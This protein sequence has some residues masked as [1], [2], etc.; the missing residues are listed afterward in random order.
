MDKIVPLV[1]H[2]RRAERELSAWQMQAG[3]EPVTQSRLDMHVA[4]QLLGSSYAELRY[5][6]QR[7]YYPQ[8]QVISEATYPI[9]MR[10]AGTGPWTLSECNCC[11]TCGL[12][13]TCQPSPCS[14]PDCQKASATSFRE[15]MT[16]D[17]HHVA[18]NH[19]MDQ[20]AL[21]EL[22]TEQPVEDWPYSR[23]R[24]V[25]VAI[26][27]SFTDPFWPTQPPEENPE[28]SQSPS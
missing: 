14:E 19:I 18:P 10:V 4:S 23:Y 21:V 25:A 27:R 12:L 11:Q 1:G 16:E 3:G 2:Y 9:R 13:C 15:M 28:E 26:Q 24:T 6:S 20:Y 5:M 22:L 7:Q 17:Y 8:Q